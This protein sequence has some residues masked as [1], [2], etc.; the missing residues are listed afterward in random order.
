MWKR[1]D[2]YLYPSLKLTR[3]EQNEHII[4]VMR[5]AMRQ[6]VE[7]LNRKRV[8]FLT[9]RKP[10]IADS[11]SPASVMKSCVAWWNRK[12]LVHLDVHINDFGNDGKPQLQKRSATVKHSPPGWKDCLTIFLYDLFEACWS[13]RWLNYPSQRQAFK[14]LEISELGIHSMVSASQDKGRGRIAQYMFFRRCTVSFYLQRLPFIPPKCA[15]D[16]RIP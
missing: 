8:L 1:A 9:E 14:N 11:H 5:N 10:P 12:R 15:S 7:K 13:R 6:F 16:S 3:I 2:F 4:F